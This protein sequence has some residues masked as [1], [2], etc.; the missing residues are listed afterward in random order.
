MIAAAWY[1]RCFYG[2]EDKDG[3]NSYINFM[4][5]FKDKT[6]WKIQENESWTTITSLKG[7]TCCDICK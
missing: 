6:E 2:D 1:S 7:K 4:G 5:M 3:Q